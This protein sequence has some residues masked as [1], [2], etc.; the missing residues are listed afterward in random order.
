MLDI[1]LVEDRL[2]INLLCT[3]RISLD[4]LWEDQRKAAPD[5]DHKGV[6]SLM[7]RPQ[8]TD[9]DLIVLLSA[10]GGQFR[11]LQ[12]VLQS[13]SELARREGISTFDETQAVALFQQSRREVLRQV[14]ERLENFSRCGNNRVDEWADQFRLE[15]RTSLARAAVMR[16]S[17]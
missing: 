11:P 1:E 13:A 6:A 12:E 17:L 5:S 15:R 4:A 9:V 3:S 14:G 2:R 8:L 7:D 16:L 10:S